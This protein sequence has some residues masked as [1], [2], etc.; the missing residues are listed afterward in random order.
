MMSLG[1]RICLV[2][3]WSYREDG[4]LPDIA[5]AS[6]ISLLGLLGHVTAKVDGIK[7][8]RALIRYRED[9]L[10]GTNDLEP[11]CASC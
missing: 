8:L 6:L 5:L 4:R 11:G 7:V 2:S 10:D 1:W 9:H 3:F